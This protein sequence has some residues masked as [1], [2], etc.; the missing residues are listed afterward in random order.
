MPVIYPKEPEGGSEIVREGLLA[1]SPE[2]L[3]RGFRFLAEPGQEIS[4]GPPHPQ[5]TV[6]LDDLAQGK[7]LSAAVE[8]GWSYPLFAGDQPV[9]EVEI[10]P[11]SGKKEALAFKALH[12]SP[13]SKAATDALQNAARLD[14]VANEDYELRFLKI[15]PVYFAGLW[16]HGPS[17]DFLVPLREPPGR[18]EPNTLYPEKEVVAVL[19]PLAVRV[20]EFHERPPPG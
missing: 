12:D 18:L 14:V 20:R 2:A 5:Y 11:V 8:T 3:E 1:L 10:G 7:L 16:L 19:Q 15:P 6:T 17:D 13:F 4:H 9:G